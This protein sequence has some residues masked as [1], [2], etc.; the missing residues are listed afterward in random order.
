MAVRNRAGG[1][2]KLVP[3]LQPEFEGYIER[4]IRL[5]MEENIRAG[6]WSEGE[7]LE[8]S[9]KAHERLLPQGLETPNHYLFAIQETSTGTTIGSLWLMADRETEYPTGFIF[10]LFVDEAYRRK[11][12]ARQAM[13][14]LED[15]ARE[16]GLTSLG[17]HVFA[18]NP[19][20]FHLYQGLGYEVKSLNLAKP[21]GRTGRTRRGR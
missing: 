13:L 10:D 19:G 9:R 20:A 7:A 4:D 14:A 2:V 21:L 11:G 3:L 5:Y 18:H 12:Y 17:L 1:S 15:K 8:K 16:L 6:Y